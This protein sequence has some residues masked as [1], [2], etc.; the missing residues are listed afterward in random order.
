MEMTK[1]QVVAIDGEKLRRSYDNKSS[2]AA[3][4]MV[5]AWASAN[6]VVLGQVKTE[7]K[8]NEIKAVPELL[9]ILDIAG[10]IVTVDAA[11]CW[12]KIVGEIIDRSG[13]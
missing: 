6:H 9:K 12:K 13:R 10:C 5:R 11:G 2:K 3:V 4:H 8:S 7:E 1:G